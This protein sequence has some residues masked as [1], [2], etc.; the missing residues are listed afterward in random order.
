MNSSLKALAKLNLVLS[1]V[2]LVL[3]ELAA[4]GWYSLKGIPFLETS[5]EDLSRIYDHQHPYFKKIL[6]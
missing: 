3:V 5:T 4:R 2:L 6:N 1:L